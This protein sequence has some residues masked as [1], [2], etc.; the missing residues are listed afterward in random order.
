MDFESNDKMEEL[1]ELLPQC[2]AEVMSKV[3]QIADDM[4][5]EA[6]R[7]GYTYAIEVL[8]DGLVKRQSS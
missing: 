4:Q 8:K 2:G 6:F 5:Q 7:A 1:K 3:L